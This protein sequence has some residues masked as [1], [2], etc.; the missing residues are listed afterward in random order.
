MLTVTLTSPG[1]SDA[2][3]SEALSHGDDVNGPN[4]IEREIAFDRD[5]TISS[6]TWVV[7]PDR[8]LSRQ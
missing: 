2:L 5:H 4:A 7:K 1:S 6:G 3:T 8:P